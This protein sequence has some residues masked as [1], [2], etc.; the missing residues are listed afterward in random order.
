MNRGSRLSQ[1]VDT[2]RPI[3]MNERSVQLAP[4]IALQTSDR[5]FPR[6]PGLLPH[7][8]TFV[9]QCGLVEIEVV[10]P[11][12]SLPRREKLD[13]APFAEYFQNEDWMVLLGWVTHGFR[14]LSHRVVT[15]VV[16]FQG[17]LLLV[18]P[19]G[20]PPCSHVWIHERED[21]S[22]NGSCL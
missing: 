12:F 18:S 15:A 14:Q 7:P 10:R 17:A 1:R 3:R 2:L 13:R 9:S 6:Q 4:R 11:P 8:A 22:P 5:L 16:T 19:V 20:A 21:G